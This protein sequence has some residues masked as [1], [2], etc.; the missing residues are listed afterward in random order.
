M[1][2]KKIHAIGF[3]L[4]FASA[5]NLSTVARSEPGVAI[6]TSVFT[7]ELH[8]NF[9][10]GDSFTFCGFC[11]PAVSALSKIEEEEKTENTDPNI[12]VGAY[13]AGSARRASKK[14]NDSIPENSEPKQADPSDLEKKDQIN[15]EE[16]F[17]QLIRD[18]AQ[19]K[20]SMD[21]EVN[22]LDV[23]VDYYTRQGRL[24]ERTVPSKIMG[25]AI[26]VMKI[27]A[28]TTGLLDVSIDTPGG[29]IKESFPG[30]EL[31]ASLMKVSGLDLVMA[32]SKAGK[33]YRAGKIATGIA[34]GAGILQENKDVISEFVE[35]VNIN[36]VSIEGDQSKK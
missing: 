14:N 36:N 8:N 4:F 33:G 18:T 22:G 23:T 30:V 15:E 3:A 13:V 19:Y 12:E 2:R 26:P 24:T 25:G 7:F 32:I 35:H 28:Q 16:E 5:I 11:D 10:I 27:E 1:K 21:M 20:A 31:N 9:V 34:K 6:E 29:T 17:N